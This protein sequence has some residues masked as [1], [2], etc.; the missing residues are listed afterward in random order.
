[1][2]TTNPLLFILPSSCRYRL[3]LLFPDRPLE[4]E[5][6]RGDQGAAEQRRGAEG[7][8]EGERA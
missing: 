3:T 1:M 4:Q 6:S 5:H 7:L 2:E 8:A